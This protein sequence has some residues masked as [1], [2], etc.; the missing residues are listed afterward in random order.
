MALVN[1]I[2]TS[3]DRVVFE[4][5]EFQKHPMF[6]NEDVVDFGSGEGLI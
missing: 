5:G 2:K 6:R 1:Q 4:T 3:Q